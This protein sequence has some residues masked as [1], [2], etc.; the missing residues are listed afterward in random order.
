MTSNQR[1]KPAV[2]STVGIGTSIG[3]LRLEP[4]ARVRLKAIGRKPLLPIL[5]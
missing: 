1:G 5:L 2:M 4:C 3:R